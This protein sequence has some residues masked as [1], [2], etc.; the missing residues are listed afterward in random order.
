MRDWRGHSI[1]VLLH[2]FQAIL[3]NCVNNG[4]LNLVF[5]LIISFRSSTR[6]QSL[7]LLLQYEG[8]MALDPFVHQLAQRLLLHLLR[9]PF[10]WPH[11]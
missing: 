11:R 3:S 1:Q 9:H 4:G 2:G 5:G 10:A 6:Y 7:L 8:P